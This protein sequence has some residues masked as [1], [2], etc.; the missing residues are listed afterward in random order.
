VG[1]LGW[2][3]VDAVFRARKGNVFVCLLGRIYII[4]RLF[5]T[6]L[7]RNFENWSVWFG[8][9]GSADVAYVTRVA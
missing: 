3:A 5:M 8:V 9:Y 7:D 2:M 4:L 1:V 6:I